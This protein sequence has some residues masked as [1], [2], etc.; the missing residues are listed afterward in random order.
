[1]LFR[2]SPFSSG[3]FRLSG[4][5][6]IQFFGLTFLLLVTLLVDIRHGRESV[7]DLAMSVARTTAS[8][9]MLFRNFFCETAIYRK[10][11]KDF[12]PAPALARRKD[13]DIISADGAI[14]T[15]ISPLRL[16]DGVHQAV[17]SGMHIRRAIK[18]FQ[19]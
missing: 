17:S 13:R 12:T 15:M 5:I 2:N 19:L 18:A 9:E 10:V 3:F 1:M 6:S 11:T 8:E 4:I 7:R 14:Y 16:L